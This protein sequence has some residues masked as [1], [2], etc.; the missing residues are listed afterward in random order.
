MENPRAGPLGFV[1]V[2]NETNVFYQSTL[3]DMKFPFREP[4]GAVRGKVNSAPA[5]PMNE[6]PTCWDN[7]RG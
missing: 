6:E 4:F 3:S 7:P 5:R 2:V 1:R